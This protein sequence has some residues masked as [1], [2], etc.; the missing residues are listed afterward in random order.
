VAASDRGSGDPEQAAA[1]GVRAAD[2]AEQLRSTRSRDYL[3]DLA[4]RLAPH[5]GLPAVRDFGER[6]RPLIQPD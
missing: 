2:A 4:D 1:V 5:V 3:R 6:V